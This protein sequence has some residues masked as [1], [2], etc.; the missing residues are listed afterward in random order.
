MK[1]PRRKFLH[2]AASAV[3]LP[4]LSRI[5]LAQAYPS[6]PVHIF[7]GLAAGGP[8]D[9]AARVLAEWL[10]QQLKQQFIV[11][12]RTGMSGNLANQAAFS[13]P[14]DGHTLLFTG[15]NTTISAAL[16]KKL[17]YDLFQDSI[18]VGSMMRFPNIMVVPPNLPIKTVKEFIDYA[19][20]HPGELSMASS[21]VGASPHLSGELFKF[22]TNIDTVHVP[23]RGSAAV[24]PDLISGKVH[25][26]FDNLSGP[27]LQLI[28]SG[29]LRAL[30]VTSARRWESL[31]D[32]PAI[33]ETVPGYEVSIWYGMFAPR[34]TSP[35]IVQALNRSINA[36][37]GDSK[38][39]ARIAEGGGRPMPMTLAE[40]GEFVR[41]DVEKWRKV[42]EF[43]KISAD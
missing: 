11:E 19:K 31:P 41:D 43:A 24:Y 8:T 3:A 12:N 34:N 1:L 37:L 40:F 2:L 15:P 6:R 39:L 36:A 9:T 23:Y 42:V 21:G 22:M 35:E 4:A 25:V 7:V 33:A 16:Y 28:Q 32:M 18:A 10:S 27:V 20:S 26:L 13:S 14:P 38:V 30:G 17:P 5:T 29:Q